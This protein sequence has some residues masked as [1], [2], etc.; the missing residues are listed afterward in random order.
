MKKRAILVLALL[1]IVVPS[2]LLAAPI[3]IV[4]QFGR[5]QAITPLPSLEDQIITVVL[6]EIPP[7]GG[8]AGLESA[9]FPV[10]GSTTLGS[11]WNI[12]ADDQNV[13]ATL[14]ADSNTFVTNHGGFQFL[15]FRFNLPTP[16]SGLTYDAF[17]MVW[18]QSCGESN[19]G[20]STVVNLVNQCRLFLNA[21]Y[22]AGT[23]FIISPET[24]YVQ[25]IPEP[26]TVSLVGLGMASLLMRHRRRAVC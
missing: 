3:I 18:P 16:P 19:I 10:G 2:P 7:I 26:A 24:A 11:I 12:T 14:T 1:A 9:T 20:P 5:V 17:G 8:A 4:D 15:D 23:Q 25:D 22:A 21:D 6:G 13:Y